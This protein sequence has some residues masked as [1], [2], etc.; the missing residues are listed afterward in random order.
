VKEREAAPPERK[1]P[2]VS[3]RMPSTP[4]SLRKWLGVYRDPWFGEVSICEREGRVA[5][6]S[7]KSPQLAGAI[8]DVNGLLLVDW[9]EDS[10]DAEAWLDFAQAGSATTLKMSK[11][12]PEADFSYDYEDLSFDRVRV[13]E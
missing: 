6:A 11:V 9:Y 7:A 10:V 5:F 2:D 12:D 1:A 13:C 4:A 3:A 8:M